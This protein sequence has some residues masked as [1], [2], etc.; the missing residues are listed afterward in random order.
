[1]NDNER[2][3][4]RQ[5]PAMHWATIFV[6][7]LARSGLRDVCIAPGSRSTPLALAFYAHP[8]IQLYT[9][10]DERSAG[11]FALGLALATDRPSALVCTSG[12]AVAN[13]FPAVVEANMSQVPLLV[14]TADRPHEL[15]HSGANQTI[16]QVKIFGD[17]VQWSVDVALPEKEAPAIALRNLRTLAA[18]AVGAADGLRKGPV[19][20]NFPFRK[21]LEPQNVK[22]WKVLA[23]IITKAGAPPS[24]RIE[25]GS[26]RPLDRQV[27]ELADLIGRG[28]QG[29]IICGPRCPG[30]KFPE[31]VAMLARLCGYPLF[32]DPL[33][34][35]RFG[36]HTADAPVFGGYETYLRAYER[37]PKPEIVLRFG[38][39]PVSS[40]LNQFLAHN[41]S[42]L[43]VHVRENGVWADE[44]HMTGLFLQVNELEL[45]LSLAKRLDQPRQSDWMEAWI[46]LEAQCWQAVDKAIEGREFDGAYVA[47]LLNLL[48]DRSALLAGN[49]LPVRHVN[50]FGRPSTRSLKVFANRG[51]SGIDGNLSTGL[52][53][54]ARTPQPIT[55][56]TGDITFYHDSNGLL[57]LRH[58]ESRDVTFVVLNN[59]GGGIFRR[60]PVA[61]FEPPFNEVFGAAHGLNLA[62]I[63]R[64]YR[65]DYQRPQ[66]REEMRALLTTAAPGTQ[67]RA[68]LIEIRT[69][70][71][72]D[73]Q[74]HNEIMA[75][76]DH[77]LAD[78]WNQN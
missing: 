47:D 68:R 78:F 24:T 3:I 49:S 60:L 10:L 69:D 1:M 55:I 4:I 33:S 50:Q 23:A 70:G 41:E 5:N 6:D 15:R 64:T 76:V 45:C 57:A 37:F 44:N 26:I 22:S 73:N 51:A 36:R 53:I 54:S 32:A 30:G 42:A 58:L 11:F 65:L 21:P 66:S 46:T 62:D 13:F 71:E 40:H 59:D 75:M 2:T 35:V 38:A 7:E 63:A 28:S 17:H 8:A 48:P 16:D 19:H 12:T 34:G 14:L 43:Q 18:R 52:G 31:A 39:V 61:K 74:L 56:L 29:L 72:R 20:L 27:D 25:H 9:H 67:K 77:A